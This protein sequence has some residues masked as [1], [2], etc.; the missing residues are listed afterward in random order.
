MV[1]AS[2]VTANTHDTKAAVFGLKRICKK[3]KKV[4]ANVETIFADK[5]FQGSLLSGWVKT[6]IGATMEIKAN[7]T[8][9]GGPFIPVKKRWVIERS[10]SWL[11]DYRR[12]T[13]DHERTDRNSLAMVRL[14]SIRI[15][16]R[17][18]H[19]PAEA[20]W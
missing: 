14:A 12:L 7:L 1:D 2:V 15:L 9:A 3:L 11:Y 18:L 17:R 20:G 6:N 19:P 10:F 16:L 8:K 5:G 4:V 13:I